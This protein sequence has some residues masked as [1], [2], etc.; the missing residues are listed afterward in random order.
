MIFKPLN[1]KNKQMN[2]TSQYSYILLI[3]LGI[4]L[5]PNRSWSKDSSS[6]SERE[7]DFEKAMEYLGS[8]KNDSA[9]IIFAQIIVELTETGELETGFGLKVQFRQAEVLEKDHQ[10]EIAIQKLIHIV[11]T[12]EQK[13]AWE[14]Y[15]RAHLSLARLYEKMERSTQCLEHLELARKVISQHN[16][17]DVYPRFAIRYSSYHRIY[18]NQDSSFFY[19]NEAVRTAPKFDLDD[20]EATG[21]LLMGLLLRDSLYHESVGYFQQA[22]I[23]YNRLEDFSGYSATLINLSRLHLF[24]NQNQLALL[25]NDSSLIAAKKATEFGHDALWMFYTQY[26]DRA[27]I[28]KNLEEHDSA[29][30]YLNKGYQ[31]EMTDMANFNNDKVIAIDA[32][33]QDEKKVQKIE[34]QAMMISFEKARRKWMF[35]IVCLVVFFASILTY[36]YLRLRK[37]NRKTLQQAMALTKVNED[38]SVSLE[39]QILLQ[40]EV[41]HRV[42]NN[43]QII[44]S[45]LELQ[46]DNI[47]DE[48]AGKSLETMSNRI[49]SMA[50]IHEILHQNKG[51]EMVNLLDYTKSLCKHFRTFVEESNSPIFQLEID[52]KF[53]NLETLMPLGI[54][55]NELLTNSLK[56]ATNLEKKLKIKIKLE[57][58][59]DGFVMKYRDNGPGFPNGTLM[60]REGGLG[61]YL[62]RSM[63]RQLDGHLIC[64]NDKGA[65]C[66]IFFKEKNPKM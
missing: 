20:E 41:H 23:I 12:S 3:C 52:D 45:L 37:A 25:Y 42:K 32:L 59:Q 9:N 49:Y 5:I 66:S 46:R 1:S 63:S 50:A 39:Q 7:K 55:L 6:K 65:V 19:A 28:F 30:H 60:E 33:Y 38:L 24:N 64:T 36:Y 18:N 48:E 16:L 44:I 47:M 57:P 62:L 56:Y 14:I 29:W 8:F 58:V 27:L 61:T 10:D 13:N 11:E 2:H 15:A 43:L 35:G 34:D 22:G 40:G 54:I 31:M 26:Q 53:F 51:T 4:L 17:D 21:Y